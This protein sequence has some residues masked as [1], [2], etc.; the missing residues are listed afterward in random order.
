[1]A[2]CLSAMRS[3]EFLS[4]FSD[5]ELQEIGKCL[6]TRVQRYKKGEKVFEAG[7]PAVSMGVILQGRVY[8]EDDDAFGNRSILA[9]LH[10]GD[11]M[12]G[13]CVCAQR[14]SYLTSFIA[15]E[16]SEILLL[17][18]GT[19]YT[20]CN[21]SC[22]IRGKMLENLLKIIAAEA[23]TQSRKLKC[24]SQR[25]IRGK[26]LA[27]FSYCVQEKGENSFTI[28]F[29]RQELADFLCLNRSAMSKEL[30]KMRDDGLLRFDR[31]YFEML[32]CE[33]KRESPEQDKTNTFLKAI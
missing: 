22:S 30:G 1:M 27:F 3:V 24:L 2:D 6:L 21:K 32:S 20:N 11:T 33:V 28:R 31:N 29:S 5:D 26:L 23:V 10:R 18:C 25:S 7:Q 13:S 9:E 15:A 4:H 19:I 12:A 14:P 17:N 8:I 16:P